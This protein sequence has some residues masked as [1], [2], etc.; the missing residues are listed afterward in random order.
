MRSLYPATTDD[1]DKMTAA[2]DHLRAARNL[3]KAPRAAVR[4]ALASTEE[5]PEEGEA[6]IWLGTEPGELPTPEA[7]IVVVAPYAEVPDTLAARL[8]D[9]MRGTIALRTVPIRLRSSGICSG[10]S[11]DRHS[12]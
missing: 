10:R 1:R 4:R 6:T 2:I 9:Y 5:E 3:L 12:A 7:A 8:R 11:I